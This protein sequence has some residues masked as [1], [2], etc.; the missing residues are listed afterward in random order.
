MKRSEYAAAQKEVKKILADA[1]IALAPDDQIEIV[2]FGLGDYRKRGLGIVLKINEPE[3]CSKWL[4]LLPGQT[5]IDHYHNYKKETFFC[6][7]GDVEINIPGKQITLKAGEKYTLPPGTMHNF[8]S[9]KGAVVEE[10][11]MHD[12]NADSLFPDTNV[13][14]DVQV[15]E[16]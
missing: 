5:C 12:E 2:D 8:T 15:Q 3:Y 14:R 9:R 6:I 4:T 7:K 1:H 16:D 10:V 13:V 11:S